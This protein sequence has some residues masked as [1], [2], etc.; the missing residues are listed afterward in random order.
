MEASGGM[1]AIDAVKRLAVRTIER[2][3]MLENVSLAG[4]AV[5][6]GA[7]SVCLLLVLRELCKVAIVHVNHLLRGEERT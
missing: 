2:Y 4:V 6:G 3:R 5:S 7:D 1:S